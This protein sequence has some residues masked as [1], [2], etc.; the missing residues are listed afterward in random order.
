M[1]GV[2]GFLATTY[3]KFTA[4]PS[5]KKNWKLVKIWQNYD[6]EFVV[7]FDPFCRLYSHILWV[8]F[9]G[10]NLVCKV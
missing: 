3:G 8:G 5:S 9:S 2:V 10:V 1:Q 4:K 7:F 6:Y